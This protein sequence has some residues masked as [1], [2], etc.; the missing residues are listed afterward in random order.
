MSVCPALQTNPLPGGGTKRL[1]TKPLP[2]PVLRL[3]QHPIVGR[4]KLIEKCLSACVRQL[5]FAFE[6]LPVWAKPPLP[7]N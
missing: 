7:P 1:R 5:D 3:P 2:M 6:Y 4:G